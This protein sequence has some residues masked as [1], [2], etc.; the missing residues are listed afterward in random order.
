LETADEDRSANVCTVRLRQRSFMYQN[1]VASFKV[2]RIFSTQGRA[3][4]S[5]SQHNSTVLHSSL[6]NPRRLTPSGFFGRTPSMISLT[7][8]MSDWIST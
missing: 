3:L 2:E 7:T 6:L 5:S 8:I 4:R 1:A